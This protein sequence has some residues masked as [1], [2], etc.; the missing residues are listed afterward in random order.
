M[1]EHRAYHQ[2]QSIADVGALLG[3]GL[4]VG[5]DDQPQILLPQLEGDLLR[6]VVVGVGGE[7]LLIDQVEAGDDLAD[8]AARLTADVALPVDQ[9]L[10][11]KGQGLGL[12]P[13]GQ[14]GE[15]LLKDVQIGPQ[16]LPALGGA[17]G[18]DDVA[19]FLLV[20]QHVHQPQVVVH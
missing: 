8:E 5:I 18:L 12:L 11:E 15:V 13:H 6:R 17:G 7:L 20:R 10:I 4:V 9:Q 19:K 3:G 2:L 16:L 1:L 14:I